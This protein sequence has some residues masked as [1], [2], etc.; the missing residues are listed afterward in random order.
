MA[1][2]HPSD[3]N[4]YWRWLDI[5]RILPNAANGTYDLDKVQ[6]TIVAAKDA[7]L[8]YYCA[9]TYSHRRN[10]MQ[11]VVLKSQ[12]PRYIFM[13]A[14]LPN[15]DVKALQKALF[16]LGDLKWLSR[17]AC[18]IPTASI[19]KIT[20]LVAKEDT[21]Y[22]AS[23]LIEHLPKI[24][25]DNMKKFKKTILKSKKG[26]YCYNLAKHLISRKEIAQIEDL[27]IEIEAWTYIR[28]LAQTHPKADIEKLEKAI[29]DSGKVEEVRKFA[30]AV[31]QSR[32]SKLSVLF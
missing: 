3:N 18:N 25:P 4:D 27:L 9:E 11:E 29:L 2:L 5:S 10:R 19:K 1:L 14:S 26:K 20:N 13:F 24:D 23:M 16:A 32:S 12:S 15:A 7:G 21:A 28:L 30:K 31:K 8:A 22:C 17:F 6:D